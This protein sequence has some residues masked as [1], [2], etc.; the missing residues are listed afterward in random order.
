[1]SEHNY[2]PETGRAAAQRCIVI[3]GCSGGGK[4][5][6]LAALSD[7]GLAVFEE[8]GRQIV[9]EQ[10]FIGGNALPWTDP[11]GFAELCVSRAM[12]QRIDATRA[13][14]SVSI[15][16]RGII[17]AI[18]FLEYL[19]L[20]VPAHLETAARRLRYHPTVWFA[21]PWPQLFA[22]DEQRRHDFAQALA[23]YAS[24]RLG[25]Q[26]RGYC[27]LELPRVPLEERVR[28]VLEQLPVAAA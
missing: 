13:P 6:L 3:S 25:Y 20:P 9:K 16:D 26:R 19:C 21:P 7:A 28:F 15:F 8:P 22:S 18:S 14:G 27:L 23:Q 10:L 11:P 24:L 5:T 2:Q 1:M 12:H 4:S 17:D